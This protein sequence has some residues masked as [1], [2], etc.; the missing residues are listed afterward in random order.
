MRHQPN[1]IGQ[2]LSNHCNGKFICPGISTW[3]GYSLPFV[4]KL[5]SVMAS[6]LWK[7]FW[8]GK[9]ITVGGIRWFQSDHQ[10][11][12]YWSY[13]KTHLGASLPP[14]PVRPPDLPKAYC[15]SL[16]SICCF[17]KDSSY[18]LPLHDDTSQVQPWVPLTRGASCA[19][20][21]VISVT[22]DMS[23]LLL[24]VCFSLYFILSVTF[25]GAVFLLLSPL[26]TVPWCRLCLTPGPG[27]LVQ[28]M[29]AADSEQK[30][31]LRGPSTS[32]AVI[33]PLKLLFSCS[34]DLLRG[35]RLP[36]SNE[37]PRGCFFWF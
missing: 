5:A 10:S 4:L 21:T 8:Q 12:N 24:L 36:G 33:Q 2:S 11:S 22:R 16:K 37:E 7:L 20:V 30:G 17:A 1:P 34:G 15:S 6:K 23:N 35:W 14:F 31:S 3:L 26:Q 27:L 19:T 9:P 29:R 28:S 32:S 13:P 18:P 25:T